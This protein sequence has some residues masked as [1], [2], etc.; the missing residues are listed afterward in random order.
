MYQ[1]KHLVAIS[2]SSSCILGEK[3]TTTLFKITYLKN[4]IKKKKTMEKLKK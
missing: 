2:G 3:Y 4:V 1:F